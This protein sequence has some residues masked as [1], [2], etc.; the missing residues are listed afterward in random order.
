MIFLWYICKT[1]LAMTLRFR[2]HQAKC[3]N[4]KQHLAI[5][6]HSEIDHSWGFHRARIVNTQRNTIKRK[7][8]KSLFP[9]THSTVDGN[10]SSVPLNILNPKIIKQLKR[11]ILS[12]LFN[13]LTD[14]GNKSLI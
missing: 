13:Q 11:V 1:T 4:P 12:D 3:R 6:D 10:K 8:A 7:I 14:Y 9:K 5:V 2:E